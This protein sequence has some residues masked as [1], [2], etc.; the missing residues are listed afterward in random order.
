MREI[1]CRSCIPKMILAFPGVGM[2]VAPS[3]LNHDI[4]GRPENPIIYYI[5]FQL[6]AYLGRHLYVASD[7]HGTT[8]YSNK[9]AFCCC[10]PPLHVFSR[11][12]IPRKL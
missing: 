2:N 11:A 6:L 12:T 1:T 4:P 8:L 5:S 3:H 10:T 9:T 7:A